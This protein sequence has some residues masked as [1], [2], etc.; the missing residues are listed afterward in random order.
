ME[1]NVRGKDKTL[2]PQEETPK[3]PYL[4]NA[5]SSQKRA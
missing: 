2:S 5:T 3:P 4:P 1:N